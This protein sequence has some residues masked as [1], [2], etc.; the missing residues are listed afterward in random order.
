MTVDVTSDAR[1]LEA[2]GRLL[3]AI[4]AFTEQNR[5]SRDPAIEEHLVEL[6]HRA[7]AELADRP[8]REPWPPPAD[9]RFRPGALPEVR[10]GELSGDAI[11]AGVLGHG[12]L[13]VRGL[14][15]P[16]DVRRTID[17]IERA[18]A[19][20]DAR[21][22]GGEPPDAAEARWYRPFEPEGRNLA[23]LRQFVA[24]HRGL[25]LGDS[26]PALFELLELFRAGG[27]I[28][29]IAAYLGERPAI[30]LEKTTLRC[31]PP[32]NR[33][34]TWHQDGAFIGEG[35]R[36]INVWTALTSCGGDD[37][38]TPCLDV[39][40][41]RF[42]QVLETSETFAHAVPF[43]TVDAIAEETPVVR[44]RFEAGD[45]L[46]FDE[47]FLHRTGISHGMTNDRYAVESWFFAPS[48]YPASYVPLVC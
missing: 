18:F 8:G 38:D 23:G 3:E 35:I 6:R 13:V 34:T 32:D 40:P 46:L 37:V 15:G 22:D 5:A 21:R 47:L 42:D 17:N 33:I 24:D 27:V 39:V 1:A 2:D 26:P 11:A 41:R 36:T 29:A 4:D 28:D 31:T 12:C 45:A 10:P 19:V 14:L 7:V 43:E 20:Y 48:R 44:P 30:S 25:W 9:D 16:D